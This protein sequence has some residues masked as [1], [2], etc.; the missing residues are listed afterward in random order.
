MIGAVFGLISL[1]TDKKTVK[2]NE[3]ITF[4]FEVN[5]EGNV[6]EVEEP[7]IPFPDAFDLYESKT[8]VQ[9]LAPSHYGAFR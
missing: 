6:H 7:E 3:P 4:T 1:K 5:G 2:E 8:K 9:K